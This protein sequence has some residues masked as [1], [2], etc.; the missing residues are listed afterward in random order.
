MREEV[1]RDKRETESG[2]GEL[3]GGRER[4]TEKEKES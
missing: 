3:A 2:R 1:E 4:E